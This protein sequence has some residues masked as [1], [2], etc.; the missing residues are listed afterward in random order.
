MNGE[1]E[2]GKYLERERF[3]SVEKKKTQKEKEGEKCREGNRRNEF[4][5]EII[6]YILEAFNAHCWHLVFCVSVYA[7]SFSN[8]T[9]LLLVE[10]KVATN[11]GFLKPAVS[12]Q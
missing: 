3:Q 1:G 11:L 4:L 10:K 12:P 5:I 7:H 8:W 9:I 6:D 2:G